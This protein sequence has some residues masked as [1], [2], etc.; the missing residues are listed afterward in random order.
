M[1]VIVCARGKRFVVYA[2]V[3][4]GELSY[5]ESVV[6]YCDGSILV[7]AELRNAVLRLLEG[8]FSRDNDEHESP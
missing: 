8:T 1:R 6:T 7:D 4:N 5:V 2:V 3:N